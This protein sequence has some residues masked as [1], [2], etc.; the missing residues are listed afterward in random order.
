MA[1]VN[2][3]CVD[4]TRLKRSVTA[5]DHTSDEENGEKRTDAN[6]ESEN[7]KPVGVLLVGTYRIRDNARALRR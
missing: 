3:S 4:M 5:A 6:M 7:E 1:A 2:F